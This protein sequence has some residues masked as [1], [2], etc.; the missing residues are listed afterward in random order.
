MDREVKYLGLRWVDGRVSYCRFK[1]LGLGMDCAGGG[2][3]NDCV[4]ENV[5]PSV[6]A[7]LMNGNE[8]LGWASY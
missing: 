2:T 7:N 4:L 8:R 6:Y 3:F 1:E 5:C